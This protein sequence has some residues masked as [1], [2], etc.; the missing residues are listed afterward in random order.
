MLRNLNLTK[1][2]LTHSLGVDQ[3]SNLWL[4][5]KEIHLRESTLKLKEPTQSRL[6]HKR[7]N[8][9]KTTILARADV[10]NER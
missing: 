8:R 5:G 9:Y 7:Y 2:A 6:A 3:V 10:K 4:K 1:N